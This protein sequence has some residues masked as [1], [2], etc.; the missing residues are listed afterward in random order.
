MS[1]SSHISKNPSQTEMARPDQVQ[2]SA[3][4][5]VFQVDKWQRLDR[6]LILGNEGGTYYATEKQLT[7]ENVK[8]ISECLKEDASRTIHRIV[9]ISY[10]G[11]APKNDPAIFALALAA[12]HQDLK[13]RQEA[14]S[15]LPQVCRIGTHL[16]HFARDIDKLRKWSRGL[17]TAVSKWY[18]R[19]SPE[20]LALQAIKYQQRDGWSHRDL[21]RL[22]RPNPKD[23]KKPVDTATHAKFVQQ[24]GSAFRWIVDRDH[25]G[26][27]KVGGELKTKSFPIREYQGYQ[28]TDLPALI[29]AFDQL[30]ASKD[31]KEVITLIREF[32]MPHEAVPNEWKDKPEVWEALLEGM[33]ITAIIR[34]LGK[35]TNVGLLKPLGSNTTQVVEK[36]TNE[37]VLKEG[38]VHP[39]A[40]LFAQ[41]VYAQGHGDKGK[42]SWTT[43]KPIVDALDDAFYFAFKTIRPTGKNHL[44]ALDVSGSMGC[45]YIAGTS[46]SAMEASAAMAMITMRAEPNYHLVGF[47]SASGGYGGKWGGGQSKMI[48]IDITKKT[49]LN[50]VIETVSKIPMGGTDCA[51]PMLYAMDNKLDVDTFAIY[52]DSETWHGDIHPYQ[53]LKQYREKSGRNAKLVVVGMTATEFSI[54]APDDNGM[55]D[56]VGFDTAAPD[57]MANFSM[58]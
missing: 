3:G 43:V 41:K 33:G 12:S 58:G 40:I 49:R 53:A 9:E 15:Y 32:K 5:Y 57:I 36:L 13:V 14:L 19:R 37:K 20:S 29:Q 52:T 50:T 39:I 35:M 11:R 51:L 46:L 42:L 22:A 4:G 28:K 31:L 27:R 30:H 24:F 38:R 56:V 44:L 10:A 54:A 7:F 25:L 55:L 26:E 16:F 17:R 6:F 34:N 18:L 48:E 2:N 21:L 45:S 47:S 1:Y 8:C 23:C